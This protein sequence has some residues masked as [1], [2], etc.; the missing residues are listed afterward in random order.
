VAT[1]RAE[2]ERARAN[3]SSGSQGGGSEKGGKKEKGASATSTQA[4]KHAL[5]DGKLQLKR[6]EEMLGMQR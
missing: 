6:L 5:A 2:F 1:I 3:G 4:I